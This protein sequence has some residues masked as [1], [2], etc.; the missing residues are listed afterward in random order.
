MKLEEEIKSFL[1]EHDVDVCFLTEVDSKEIDNEF[2]L[3]NYSTLAKEKGLNEKTR[4]M[5]LVK[6]IGKIM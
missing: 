3:G 6:M 5:A 2:K 4:V 1:D